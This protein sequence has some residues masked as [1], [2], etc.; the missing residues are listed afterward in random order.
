M[1]DDT[2][3]TVNITAN[4]DPAAAGIASV[5]AAFDA[6]MAKMAQTTSAGATLTASH[7]EIGRAAETAAAKETLFGESIG[8]VETAAN[9]A[10]RAAS[11][12]GLETEAAL[13][14]VEAFSGALEGLGKAAA[15]LLAIGAAVL[16]VAEAFNFLKDGVDEAAKAQVAMATLG[17]AVQNQGGAWN[18]AAQDGV[19]K[20]LT[21]IQTATTYS[22]GEALE[23]LNSLVSAGTSLADA[24]KMVAIATDVAAGSHRSL[25]EVVDKLKQAEANRT[26][27]L[28][29]LDENLKPL[30]ATH[31]QLSTILEKLSQDF[32]GDAAAA[33]DTFSGKMQQLQNQLA[34]VGEELGER[35]LPALTTGAEIL[36]GFADDAESHEPQIAHFFDTVV[37]SAER[38]TRVLSD[39]GRMANYALAA[40]T[41]NVAEVM[42]SAQGAASAYSDFSNV[43]ES[44]FGVKDPGADQGNFS[45]IIAA[46][47][48]RAKADEANAN[49]ILEGFRE[50]SLQKD[51]TV[52]TPRAGS[53]SSFDFQ[54]AAAPDLGGK[55]AD[56]AQA[57]ALDEA[58]KSLTQSEAGYDREI[59]DATTNEDKHNAEMAKAVAVT[60]DAQTAINDIALVLDSEQKKL[61]ALNAELPLQENALTDARNAYNAYGEAMGKSPTEAEKNHLK[62]LKDALDNAQRSYTATHTAIGTLNGLIDQNNA[63]LVENVKNLNAVDAAAAEVARTD[64]AAAAAALAAWNKSMDASNEAIDKLNEERATQEKNLQTENALYGASLQQQLAFYRA[65]EAAELAAGEKGTDQEKADFAKIISLEGDEYK[66]RLDAQKAFIT[67]AQALESTFL[68]DILTKHQSL[69]DSLHDIFASIEADFVKMLEQ[70][71]LKSSLLTGLNS[72]LEKLF[73]IGG[74]GTAGGIAGGSGLGG[75]FGGGGAG[76]PLNSSIFTGVD[77]PGF[78][79]DRRRRFEYE[80]RRSP[81]RRPASRR[82]RQARAS[83]RPISAMAPAAGDDFAKAAGPGLGTYVSG[84]LMGAGVG[85]TIAGITGGNQTY[86]SVGGALGSS[87]GTFIGTLGGAT[88][89]PLGSIIGT[90]LGSVVGGLFGS[91]AT[92]ATSPDIY[93]TTNY[94]QGV[95]NLT[96]NMAARTANTFIRTSSSRRAARRDRLHRRSARGRHADHLGIAKRLVYDRRWAAAQPATVPAAR[97]R[98]RHLGDGL[99][100]SSTTATTSGSSG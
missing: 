35:L 63:K 84:A 55:D 22:R 27:G 13:G 56:T 79:L 89:G 38:A 67:S 21:A 48:A 29:Q 19:D 34:Y 95:A 32:A 23:A 43:A 11:A 4:A 8:R 72:S 20:F 99:G 39:M 58:L 66:E 42:Q 97:E 40:A 88:G 47:Q 70:M 64:N 77:T 41:S 90:V 9:S 6:L 81:D 76:S 60:K 78:K 80:P 93:D 96:G 68:D 62:E 1:A 37:N 92:P 69:R 5:D 12:F 75:L 52:G 18:Q 51:M 65:R 49:K 36:I 94:G 59:A 53:G 46:A 25:E 45:Q 24:E 50:Q 2:A 87:L 30:L 82:R 31:A 85:G 54:P 3:L 15:P 16:V 100:P 17:Q 73:G 74:G 91:K 71:I 57:K 26:R 14:R 86:G 28:L 83:A 7:V 44:D 10:A 61:V 33:A 98:I